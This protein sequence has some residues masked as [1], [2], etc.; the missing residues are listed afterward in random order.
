MSTTSALDS[1]LD[2]WRDRW[3]EWE[4]AGRF[5]PADRQR[6]TLAWFALLQEFEDIMNIAGDP[7]PADAKLA[8]WQQELRDWSGRRSRH[9]LGRVLEPVVAPWAQLAESLPAMQ[10]ARAQPLSLEGALAVLQPFAEAVVA[11]EAALFGRARA[12]NARAVAVQW[13][14]TR[15]A[16][17]GAAAAPAGVNVEAWRGQLL[18]QWPRKAALALPHRVWSRMA[19]LRLARE[20]QGQPAWAPPLQQLWHAWR[21]ASG[22]A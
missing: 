17:A 22:G 12:A 8:W 14:S 9:P 16:S 13:L 11:V 4:V 2:K 7:L 10:E 20:H 18:A 3:P 6:A 19:R 15:A 1:F 5:V 21:A